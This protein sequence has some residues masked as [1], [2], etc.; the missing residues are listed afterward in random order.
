MKEIGHTK[1]GTV[2]IEYSLEEWATIRGVARSRDIDG[3]QDP[4]KWAERFKIDLQ[5]LKL[6]VR[7]YNALCR[8]IHGSYYS[9]K[10]NSESALLFAD[11]GRFLDFEEWVLVTRD[12]YELLMNAKGIGR[13]SANHIL[14]AV[15]NYLKE[16][17]T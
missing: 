5:H 15:E 9:R 10:I 2:I 14:M 4:E 17:T 1:H 16:A 13:S 7:V 3:P 11:N 12:R 8:Y 6:N